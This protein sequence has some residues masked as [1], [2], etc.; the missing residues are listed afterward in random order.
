VAA[1][2]GGHVF[3]GDT[4]L[5]GGC[6]RTDVQSGSAEALFHSL[7]QILFKLPENTTVWPG[8]D[9]QGR[10]HSSIAQELTHNVRIAGQSTAQFV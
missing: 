3:T 5:I 4:L 1:N 10:T 9:Y 6:G 2:E 7:T 8:H